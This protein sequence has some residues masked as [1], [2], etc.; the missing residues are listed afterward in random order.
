MALA[1]SLASNAASG[2]PSDPA[3]AGVRLDMRYRIEQVDQGGFDRNALASTL[4]TR[5]GY[6]TAQRDGWSAF[7]SMQD[8]RAVGDDRYNSTRNGHTGYPVVA[9]PG[10]TELDQ[11][12]LEYRGGNVLDLR[13]GRQVIK[14]DNDR[15][16]GNVGFRQ[17]EQSFD[18]LRATWT[19]AS[20]LRIDYAYLTRVNRVFG[21]HHPD[22]L[23]ARQNLDTHLLNASW[24]PR[25]GTLTA[26]LYL[27]GNQSLP[28]TSHRD[29]GLRWTGHAGS[30]D[31]WR[32]GYTLEAARQHAWR[33]GTLSGSR[34]Y[35]HAEASLTRR[36]WSGRVG[37]ERLGGN[38]RSAF[39]TPLA[40]LHAFNGWADL[41]LVTPPDGL[42][43]TYAGI[44]WKPNRLNI[45][46]IAHRFDSTRGSIHYGN[47]LDLSAG[48]DLTRKL[49]TSLALADYRA[50]RYAVDKRVI[51]FTLQYTH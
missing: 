27:I 17:L 11:A 8:N 23:H 39:Q 37:H 49:K 38:G 9:D 41:F 33:D 45:Q 35:V 13:A 4:R 51:W 50:D 30:R 7:V 14:L 21:A 40:T 16:I 36:D 42:A 6:Q 29:L 5:L 18:A 28:A 2:A 34:N 47:E 22:P 20:T 46:A 43:D 25:F 31:G 26:Y 15:F 48:L 3:D 32:L 44:G 12:Y 24:M 19:P 1:L 10:D